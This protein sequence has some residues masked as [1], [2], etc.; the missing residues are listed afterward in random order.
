MFSVLKRVT[1]PTTIYKKQRMDRDDIIDITDFDVVAWIKGEMRVMLNEEIARAILIGDGRLANS[2]DKIDEACIRPMIK[3]D[4]LFNTKIAVSV[5]HGAAIDVQAKTLI[6]SVIRGRKHYKGSGNPILFTTEDW[7]T[8]MLLIEDGI[9]HKLYR[10]EAE[11]ATALRVSRIVTV[12]VLENQTVP[13]TVTEGQ[14]TTTVAKPLIGIIINPIDY[15]VG[16]DKGGSIELF[17]DFD[18]DFNQYVW[19][20]ET[21]LS[22]ALTKPFS[23]LT[24]Y[25]DEAAAG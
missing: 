25:L 15:N 18:I 24:L 13:V 9:G 14:S 23:A 6:N 11:L 2:P 10:T 3:D 17:D 21:R 1:T 22:G 20:M 4:P 7:V 8:E 12:E 16:A 19:L 5:A